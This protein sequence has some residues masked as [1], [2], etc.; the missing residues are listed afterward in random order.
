MYN[1]LRL[2]LKYILYYLSASSRKGHGIHSPFVYDFIRKVLGDK[3]KYP[4]YAR[5]EGLRK[6]LLCD[7]GMVWVDDFGAGSGSGKSGQRSVR[8][9][10]KRAAKSGKYGQLIFRMANYYQPATILELGTSLGL[11]SA[12]LSLG[13]EKAR[14]IT[15]EGASGIAELARQ[16]FLKL[17]LQKIEIVEGDFDLTL[18]TALAGIQNL[19]LVFVDGNHRKEPTERYFMSL[20]ERAHNDSVFIFDDIHWSH[21]MEEAWQNIIRHP[22]VRCSIDL[23]FLGIIFFRKEFKEPVHQVIRF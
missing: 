15:M 17:G 9:I 3:K 10:A 13:A 1:P 6:Q 11:T 16:N 12:Y 14:V 21:E 19:D 22:S 23:F 7:T 18:N 4:A 8:S 2:S 5:V 20:L